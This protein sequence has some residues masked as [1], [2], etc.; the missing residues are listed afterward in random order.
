MT[1]GDYRRVA[2]EKQDT[3]LRTLDQVK[4]SLAQA[5]KNRREAELARIMLRYGRLT[6]EAR[7]YVARD[8]RND[9]VGGPVATT[10]ID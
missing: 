2:A 8:I 6:D 9:L 10:T 5:R 3:S 7:E 4:D 1:N